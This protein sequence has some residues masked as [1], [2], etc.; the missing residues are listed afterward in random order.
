MIQQESTSFIDYQ[1]RKTGFTGSKKVSK[2][3]IGD[4]V[5]DGNGYVGIVRNVIDKVGAHLEFMDGWV[6]FENE[7]EGKLKK[8]SV[9][10]EQFFNHYQNYYEFIG[11]LGKVMKESL[12]PY[13]PSVTLFFD[14]KVIRIRASTMQGVVK[15]FT[16][17][18]IGKNH[19][20]FTATLSP[21]YNCV[22]KNFEVQSAKRKSRFSYNVLHDLFRNIDN[23]Q[24]Q[25]N[26]VRFVIND[27]NDYNKFVWMRINKMFKKFNIRFVGE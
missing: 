17:A 22:I 21:F 10:N 4:I 1:V 20:L 19:S 12:E 16:T 26:K 23:K 5:L 14:G 11:K 27:S 6:G 3:E 9:S 24:T 13:Y 18:K 15:K 25:A 7:V 8:I 2:L